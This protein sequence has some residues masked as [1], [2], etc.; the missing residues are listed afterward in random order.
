M[1]VLNVSPRP[2]TNDLHQET[3][4]MWKLCCIFDKADRVVLLSTWAADKKITTCFQEAL[5]NQESVSFFCKCIGFIDKISNS[6]EKNNA[7]I[8]FENNLKHVEWYDIKHYFLQPAI[9]NCV[10]YDFRVMHL[11]KS[12]C[13]AQHMYSTAHQ[14]FHPHHW[15]HSPN[16]ASVPN[17]IW[18][19]C[20][21]LSLHWQFQF[22][23]SPKL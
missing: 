5:V 13:L 2:L 21:I 9:I 14:S 11:F 20:Q 7:T 12:I 16:M 17:M 22:V 15:R 6:M 4:L 18:D 1:L 19:P 3:S 8:M 10:W 23:C